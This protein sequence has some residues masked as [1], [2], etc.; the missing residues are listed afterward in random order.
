MR[1][2]ITV[3]LVLLFNLAI[4]TYNAANNMSLLSITLN[5]SFWTVILYDEEITL[6]AESSYIIAAIGISTAIILLSIIIVKAYEYVQL[7]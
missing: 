6:D 2:N 4:C 1:G 5:Y 7:W 3:T